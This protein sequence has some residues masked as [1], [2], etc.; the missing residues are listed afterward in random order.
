MPNDWVLWTLGG[1]I[2]NTI[3]RVPY[4]C[5]SIL[6][7]SPKPHP[8]LETEILE[9]PKPPEPEPTKPWDAFKTLKALRPKS[10]TPKPKPKT[11]NFVIRK[12]CLDP[13]SR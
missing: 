6:G 3:L 1:R 8:R 12:Y 4:Y 7:I 5:Y 11:L 10:K 9:N 13:K 2:A